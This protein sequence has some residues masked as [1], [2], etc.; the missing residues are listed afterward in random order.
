MRPPN[1]EVKLHRRSVAVAHHHHT[2]GPSRQRPRRDPIAYMAPGRSAANRLDAG[3]RYAAGILGASRSI[4]T[5][6]SNPVPAWRGVARARRWRML[7][8]H[9]PTR[10]PGPLLRFGGGLASE[11]R[12]VS[13]PTAYRS[14]SGIVGR[15]KSGSNG[16]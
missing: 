15:P 12:S 11:W 16:I 13:P 1:G 8:G 4:Y 6:V 9:G 5:P 2:E 10:L 3:K 7:S 14:T